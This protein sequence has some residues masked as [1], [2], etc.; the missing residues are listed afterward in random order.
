MCVYSVKV[1]KGGESRVVRKVAQ[2]RLFAGQGKCHALSLNVCLAKGFNRPNAPLS[3]YKQTQYS[4]SQNQSFEQNS[5]LSKLWFGFDHRNKGST[6]VQ[7]LDI[8]ETN[9]MKFRQQ[10]SF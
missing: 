5:K 8:N 3:V 6:N 2:P 7:K 10:N 1:N 9:D 4:P